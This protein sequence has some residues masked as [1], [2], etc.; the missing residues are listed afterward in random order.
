MVTVKY[1]PTSYFVLYARL[2][3]LMVASLLLIPSQGMA[4]GRWATLLSGVSSQ[5]ISGYECPVF[6]SGISV[7]CF[8]TVFIIIGAVFKLKKSLLNLN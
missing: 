4:Q 5:A 8:K 1:R 6:T 2:N 7:R 3:F